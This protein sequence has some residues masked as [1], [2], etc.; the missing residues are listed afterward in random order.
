MNAVNA[1]AKARFASARPQSA[2]LHEGGAFDLELLCMEAG[3][4]MRITS[5]EWAYYVVMGQAEVSCGEQASAV[6]TG[7]LASFGANE[8]HTIANRGAGR[9]VCLVVKSS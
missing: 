5:G 7:H 8:S 3:Q 1:V 6:S 4:E 2:H 9:L